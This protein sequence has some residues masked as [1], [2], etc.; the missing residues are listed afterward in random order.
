[1][2]DP[3]PPPST[4]PPSTPPRRR[5]VVRAALLDALAV[6]LPVDCVGCGAPD[7][8]LCDSCR[9]ELAPL[10]VERRIPVGDDGPGM[11]VVAGLAYGGVARRALVALKEQERTELLGALAPPLAAA[12]VRLGELLG[13][14]ADP[15]GDLELCRVPTSRAAFRRR[16][17]EPVAQL[18][19]R[20][21][22]R[23]RSLL[24]LGGAIARQKR[25]GV[26]ER[27]ENLRGAMSARRPL[28]G[29]RIV[30]VDDVVTTG[31]TLAEAAR[32][33][34]A[35]GGEVLGAI[36]VASTPKLFRGAGDGASTVSARAPDER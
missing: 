20:A 28:L 34:Q 36:V 23:T 18:A 35:A 30:L 32:A 1:M 26:E 11:L 2:T 4:P 7:R 14:A 10:P 29:R 24:R 3:D 12:A 27:A 9:A 25:L 15:G 33:V 8:A 19:D 17:R 31:A 16:G 22:L 13:P 21:G 5:D 6:V